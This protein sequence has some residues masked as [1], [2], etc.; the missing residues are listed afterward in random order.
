MTTGESAEITGTETAE[1]VRQA[2]D[3]L[4][5]AGRARDISVRTIYQRIQYGSQTTINN[6]LAQWWA[7]LGQRVREH[8]QLPGLP[9]P[10]QAQV[11]ALLTTIQREAQALAHQQWLEHERQANLRVEEATA[12]RE[13]AEQAQQRSAA[14]V[15]SLRQR[16]ESLTERTRSLEGDLGAE[17]ARLQ[18]AE[19]H[20]DAA[21]AESERVRTDAASRVAQLEQQQGLERERLH[22][23]ESRLIAQLDEHKTARTRLEQLKNEADQAWRTTERE[24]MTRIYTQEQERVRLEQQLAEE[25]RRSEGLAAQIARRDEE[26]HTLTQ[27]LANARASGTAIQTELA[28]AQSAHE[29]EA[30]RA[31]AAEAQALRLEERLMQLASGVT[32]KMAG[33]GDHERTA[34]AT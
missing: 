14:E 28:R 23:L 30:R 10:L 7:E 31:T 18:A 4:L 11:V 12:S 32:E 33:E 25:Q 26:I 19:H 24:L 1:R 6:A 20:L 3:E 29:A 27:A 2:A 13:A 22:A 17:R 34:G 21:R 8:E 5:L 15:E 9:E 16:L